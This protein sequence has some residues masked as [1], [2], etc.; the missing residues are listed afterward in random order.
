MGGVGCL[1]RDSCLY[2]WQLVSNLNGLG[3]TSLGWLRPGIDRHTF[4]VVVITEAT[5]TTHSRFT[6]VLYEYSD[7]SARK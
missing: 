5:P 1:P 3:A 6:W 4:K 2:P 7:V